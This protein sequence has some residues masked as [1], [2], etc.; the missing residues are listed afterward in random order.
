MNRITSENVKEKLA[1]LCVDIEKEEPSEL[2]NML[3]YLLKNQG[4]RWTA[5]F[6]ARVLKSNLPPAKLRLV[7][8]IVGSLTK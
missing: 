2:L 6:F 4:R 1:Q 3:S 5:E 8:S 7:H